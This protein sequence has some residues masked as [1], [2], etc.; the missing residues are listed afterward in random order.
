MNSLASRIG[1]VV[2]T[3][4]VAAA[5]FFV[6]RHVWNYYTYAPWTRDGHVRADVL[7]LAPDV[8]G[9]ITDVRVETKTGGKSGDWSRA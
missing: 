1:P 4:L 8:S 7:Q 6:G 2:L 3:L 9:L 5:A